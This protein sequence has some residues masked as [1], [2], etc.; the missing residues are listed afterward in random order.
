MLFSHGVNDE[1]VLAFP[2]ILFVASLKFDRASL[3][4]TLLIQLSVIA[5]VG[6]L[7]INGF[8]NND[9]SQTVNLSKLINLSIILIIAAFIIDLLVSDSK[10]Y[11]SKLKLSSEELAKANQNLS[12]LVATKV[13]FFSIVAHDLRSPFQGLLGIANILENLD[14]EL[15]PKERRDFVVRLNVALK[16]QYDFLEE[17]LLWGKFQKNV[18]DFD[19]QYCDLKE[20]VERNYQILSGNIEKKKLNFIVDSPNQVYLTCDENLISTVIRNLL[21]NAIKYTPADGSISISLKEEFSFVTIEV[22][23]TGIGLSDDRKQ[24]LFQ[25]EVN[26]STRGTE[27]EAGTGLGLILCKEIIEKHS[28]EISVKSEEG[29]GASFV[30]KLPKEIN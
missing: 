26:N 18:V 3:L 8:V 2:I 16:R 12:S 17:L 10:A 27:D 7:E 5:S 23:D 4:L 24:Q 20:I 30:I 15:T 21:S 11:L 9:L 6:Y 14:E 22:S 29:K 19:P 28:G 25:V 13:K 1:I